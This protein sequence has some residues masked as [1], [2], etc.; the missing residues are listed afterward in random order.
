M[1]RIFV[2]I[3]I[4]LIASSVIFAAV[5]GVS[6]DISQKNAKIFINNQT[7]STKVNRVVV[8]RDRALVERTAKVSIPS[9]ES[10][11]VLKYLPQQIDKNSVRVAV[12]GGAKASLGGVEVFLDKFTPEAIQSLKDSIQAID[13]RLNELKIEE[14]GIATQKDFLKSIASLGG[15]ETKGQQLVISPQNLT[16]TAKFLESQ[17]QKLAKEKTRI[18]VEKRELQRKKKELQEHLNNISR[19]GASRGY[20]VE[21]PIR[22]SSAADFNVSVKYVVYGA[23]WQPQ[24]DARYDEKSGRV[25]LTYFGVVKQSTTEDWDNSEIVLSTA[26]PQL[27][28][29]P[30]E[31]TKW[32]LR[33]YVLTYK[34]S[35]AIGGGELLGL[36]EDKIMPAAAPQNIEAEYSTS[37]AE[38]SGETVIFNVS[39]RRTIPSDGQDHRVVI[40]DLNFDAEKKFVAVPKLDQKVYITA[41]CKNTSDYLL[42]PGK[43]SV[44]QGNAYVGTQYFR[45]PL[46]FEREFTFAM[47][48]V[49]T[50]KISRKRTK[51]FAENTG[52]IGQNRREFFAYEI[53][54]ENNSMSDAVVEIYDQIPVSGDEDIRVED[55]KFQPSPDRRDKNFDGEVVWK[56][57]IG[58]GQKKKIMMQFAVKY[59]KDVVVQGL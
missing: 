53:E 30:P 23:G 17:L 48:S 9:G 13:D 4:F 46:G 35:R 39:S 25:E 27:G 31:L 58:K 41:K 33:K 18:A 34:K 29:E 37:T 28:T 44:F 56:I 14:E 22:N 26:Q 7:F 16:A 21:V 32:L 38:I 50:I 54:I 52:I 10:K 55:V 19:G 43:V 49:Q 15:A 1:R 5:G 3:V 59:P 2:P 51:E 57:S 40:A 36:A 6:A 42:L 24:Y 8:F 47:G 11:I 45:E 20:R 12:S